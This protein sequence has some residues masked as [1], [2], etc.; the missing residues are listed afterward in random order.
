MR[1]FQY[2]N[3][4][5]NILPLINNSASLNADQLKNVNNIA[6]YLRL[7]IGLTDNRNERIHVGEVLY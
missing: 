3:I 5:N 1:S 6:G 7:G 2:A 4:S